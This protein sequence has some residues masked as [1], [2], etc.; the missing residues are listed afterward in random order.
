[1]NDSNFSQRGVSLFLAIMV[2]S[3]ILAIALGLSSILVSQIKIIRGMGNSVVAFYAADSGIEEALS[4][5]YI[6]QFKPS[7][8]PNPSFPLING[9]EVGYEVQVACCNPGGQSQ[10][11]KWEA[12]EDCPVRDVNNSPV[13]DLICDAT[14]FCVKSHGAYQDT[15]RAIEVKIHP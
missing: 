15:T 12:A 8:T 2:L 11:C 4:D 10:N 14:F 6:D 7:Y 13:I 9:G 1:M 3:V 5:I